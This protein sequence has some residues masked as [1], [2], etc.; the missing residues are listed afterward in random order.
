MYNKNFLV[1]FLNYI[2]KDRKLREE[3]YAEFIPLPNNDE[4]CWKFDGKCSMCKAWVFDNDNYCAV[5]GAKLSKEK[6]NE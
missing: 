5:C 1:N 4:L 3:R 6:E 2:R